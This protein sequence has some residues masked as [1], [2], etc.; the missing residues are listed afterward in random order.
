MNELEVQKRVSK[1]GKPLDLN[2]FNWDEE[3]KTFSSSEN[4]LVID[5]NNIHCV[6][7]TTG[8]VCTFKTGWGCTFKTGSGCTFKTEGDCT[9]KTGWGCTFKTGSGCT[10]KTE[11]D[12]TFTTGW[13]CTFKTGS[14]CTFKTGCG[15]VILRRDIFEVIQTK[16]GEEIQICPNNIKG[17]LVNG[18]FDGKPHIIADQILSEVLSQKGNIYKVKN[19]GQDK[20]SYLVKSGDF[21]AHGKTIKEAREALLFK[22]AGRDTSA[23]KGMALDTIKSP[24]EWAVVY[25]VITG[26]C[27]YGCKAF[28]DQKG[29]LK[30]SY[31]LA[32][33]I[34][35]TEGAYQSD[36]FKCFFK[37]TTK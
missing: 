7:F 5:F 32:E 22:T 3:T 33:I 10:F 14:G 2:L 9:F 15:C 6:T 8:S 37:E 27:E 1:N 19:H 17:H 23:Y 20:I 24:M 4:Y 26:A 25:S 18:L 29:N 36:V 30:K 12:C 13:G 11:G 34:K 28:M 16:K 35:E 21:Y 31:T